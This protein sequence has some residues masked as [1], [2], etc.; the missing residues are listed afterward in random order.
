MILFVM[1]TS[2]RS[3]KNMPIGAKLTIISHK[4]HSKKVVPFNKAV[5]DLGIASLHLMLGFSYLPK[6][7]RL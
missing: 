1:K 5:I 7:S 6:A 3:G 2:S 4:Y